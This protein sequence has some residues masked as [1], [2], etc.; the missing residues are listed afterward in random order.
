MK[1]GYLYQLIDHSH[2]ECLSHALFVSIIETTK[3]QTSWSRAAELCHAQLSL[4]QVNS[5]EPDFEHWIVNNTGES[6]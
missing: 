2:N 5:L 3:I 4:R 6:N 1:H